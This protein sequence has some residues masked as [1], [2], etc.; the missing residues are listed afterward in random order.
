MILELNIKSR[1][2]KMS[3]PENDTK[4]PICHALCELGYNP[5]VT[6]DQIILCKDHIDVELKNRRIGQGDGIDIFYDMNNDLCE[7]M[8]NYDN[9]GKSKPI[10]IRFRKTGSDCGKAWIESID[11]NRNT[12]ARGD[13]KIL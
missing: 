9:E 11:A 12:I 2:I 3:T 13:I 10:T 8:S 1:H 4:D 5:I 6:H 7:W